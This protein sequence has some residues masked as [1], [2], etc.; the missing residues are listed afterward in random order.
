MLENISIQRKLLILVVV[1]FLG[2]AVTSNYQVF[3]QYRQW[4]SDKRISDYHARILPMVELVRNLH[5][6]RAAL[7]AHLHTRDSQYLENYQRL[8]A[9]FQRATEDLRA[10]NTLTESIPELDDAFQA[11]LEAVARVE[12]HRDGINVYE[13]V[14]SGEAFMTQVEAAVKH[15]FHVLALQS[16]DDELV[17]QF[18]MVES[19]FDQIVLVG[20]ERSLV[21]PVAS[22]DVVDH[23]DI[24]N[25][26]AL[27]SEQDGRRKM[28][29]QHVLEHD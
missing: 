17:E 5:D 25:L 7:F 2:F 12:Q 24:Q 9:P 26:V 11:I 3:E 27:L 22:G 15:Y 4:V 10:N 18:N 29:L 19:L 20:E 14:W 1:P 23:Q 16:R 21:Y 28:Y 13:K 6:Q 8:V